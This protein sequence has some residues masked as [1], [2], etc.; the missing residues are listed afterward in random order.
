MKRDGALPAVALEVVHGD[1]IEQHDADVLVNTWDR[2]LLPRWALPASGVFGAL[3]R[4][5]GLEP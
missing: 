4:R 1:L 2:N 5:T 3:K